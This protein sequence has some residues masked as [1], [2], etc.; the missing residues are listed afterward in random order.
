M[1]KIAAA[2]IAVQRGEV[3]ATVGER[4]H[5][6]ADERPRS[7]G[8]EANAEHVDRAARAQHERPGQLAGEEE[9]RLRAPRA[10]VAALV[11]R[12][13][14]VG[15]QLAAAVGRD[16]LLGAVLVASKRQMQWTCAASAG[17]GSCSS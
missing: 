6:H 10:V 2:L 3:E 17:S 13:A 1:R 5:R 15:D 8:L 12:P 16:R 7:G 4:R 9:R 11:V 14:A